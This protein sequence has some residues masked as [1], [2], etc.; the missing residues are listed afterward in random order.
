METIL[1]ILLGGLITIITA[2]AVEYF[3]RPSLKLNI[4]EPVLFGGGHS[5]FMEIAVRN[6]PLPKVIRLMS[7][8]AA[9]QC[10]AVITFH[11]LD[12]QNIFARS[13]EPRWSSAPE[14]RPVEIRIGEQKG[15]FLDYDRFWRS[16]RVDIH[17]GE[18]DKLCIVARHNDSSDCWG[19]SNESY[20]SQPPWRNEKWKLPHGRYLAVVTV[21]AAGE[22]AR[23][24]F[25]VINDVPMSDCRLELA[26]KDEAKSAMK[27][28]PSIV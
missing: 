19:W 26:S 2:L 1:S 17:P 12:G 9:L 16:Q 8:N 4:I 3:R 24:V 21:I 20:F 13:M 27:S 10:R 25:R 11:H 5:K 23:S 7:R 14:P 28:H 18:M 22:Y 6:Q 15:Q